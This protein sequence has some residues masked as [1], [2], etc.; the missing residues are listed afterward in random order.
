MHEQKENMDSCEFGNI[1][2][3]QGYLHNLRVGKNNTFLILRQQHN[4]IQVVIPLRLKE[5]AD[6][7]P[8]ESIIEIKGIY[9]SANVKSC[10]IKDK[11][12][13][14]LDIN[15]ISSNN[16]Q[17]ALQIHN[18]DKISSEIPTI[19]NNRTLSLRAPMNQAI[20]QIQSYITRCFRQYLD[21]KGFIEIHTP[22]IIQGASESSSGSQVFPVKYFD[23][24]RYLAQS[25]QL[26]KQMMI[27]AGYKRVYEIGP[28]FRAEPST[29]PRHLT[30]FYGLDL[31][32]EIQ[33]NYLEVV[34]MLYGFLTF[35]F[36]NLREN[37]SELLLLTDYVPLMYPKE[38]L[39]I[40]YW[41]IIKELEKTG[42]QVNCREDINIAD[43]KQ[44]G[45]MIKE[46]YNS[47]IVI[48]NKYPKNIRPFYSAISNENTSLTNSYDIILRGNEILSGSQRINDYQALLDSAKS[49]NI[50]TES[51]MEYLNS[52]KNAS[53]NHGGGG[54]GLERLTMFILNIPNIKLASLFPVYY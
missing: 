46:K 21:E 27:N 3:I 49:K 9:V 28:I 6:I 19:L 39:I 47:D 8:I 33:H 36:N 29:G 41:Q 52:F 25:P 31:E 43:E 5:E 54:F 15:V 51:L 10:S 4:T 48:I 30:Q 44:I 35:L 22:K 53:P 20:F 34:H 23:E 18:F 45:I 24:T 37:C 50:N 17:L 7:I 26:Y 12:L 1:V 13:H 38:P 14:A 42:Y 32:M 40:D 11:E 2:T 16:H